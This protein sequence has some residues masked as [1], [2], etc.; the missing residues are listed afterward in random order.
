MSRIHALFL[1]LLPL[2]AAPAAAQNLIANPGFD[3]DLSG[4]TYS[5][6]D[7]L[8]AEW[9]NED[10]NGALNSGSAR[11]INS[12][13]GFGSSFFQKFVVSPGEGWFASAMVN[14]PPG[15]PGE[16]GVEL[17][18]SE[19]EGCS[20]VTDREHLF[21][22]VTD[23]WVEVSGEGVAPPNA[24]CVWVILRFTHFS[25][26]EPVEPFEVFFDDVAFMLGEPPPPDPNLIENG[27]FNS[28]AHYDWQRTV[29]ET[30]WSEWSPLDAD[31]SAISGSALL[32]ST[33][34]STSHLKQ[35]LMNVG[36]LDTLQVSADAR[37][38]GPGRARLSLELYERSDTCSQSVGTVVVGEVETIG[39][40][41][42]LTGAVELPPTA[43]T[44][45]LVLQSVNLSGGAPEEVSIH[46]DNVFVPEP[47]PMQGAAGA[48]VTL[49]ILVTR[50]RMHRR[51]PA[52][53]PS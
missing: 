40:W 23:G 27:G 16:A 29:G 31:D 20:G 53:R 34:G 52:R 13:S 39:D 14:V 1:L 15:G 38:A 51:A 25:Q 4:W 37:V 12:K 41:T 7:G 26:P 33:A 11:G 21:V 47:G 30:A 49:A 48:L 44:V 43:V 5:I 18:W 42:S 24:V 32:L 36:H 8:V 22:A 45:R 2:I 17:W 28:N 6:Q 50:S 9:S 35:C 10:A 46:F 19:S 3:Q